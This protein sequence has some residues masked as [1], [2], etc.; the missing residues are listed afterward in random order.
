MRTVLLWAT[1][2][3]VA[4]TPPPVRLTD[5]G[6][7]ASSDDYQNTLA[8]WTRAREYYKDLEGRFFVRATYL[9][10]PFRK[11]QV[12]FRR[13]EERLTSR[14]E[15][16]LTDRH[17]EQHE[18][19]HEFFVAAYTNEW[20]W[21]T[22]NQT[23]PNALWRIRL[24]NRSGES[25]APISIRRIAPADPVH[26]ALYPYFG[27]FHTGYIVRFPR[28][29]E[30]GRPMIQDSGGAFTLRISGPKGAV[31]LTWEVAE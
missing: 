25:V 9:S 11:A 16:A 3:A 15:E 10:W 21:N 1:L 24:L 27:R 6:A 23:G 12:A 29:L 18:E 30:D 5:S 22:L 2:C 4:C 28:R 26:E 17:R 8:Q 14:D 31:D 13:D 20:Q 7:R 19:S